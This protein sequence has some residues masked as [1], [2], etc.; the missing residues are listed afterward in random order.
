[1]DQW[2]RWLDGTERALVPYGTGEY[3]KALQNI[4]G[5]PIAL[6]TEGAQLELL[7]AP[8]LAIVGS[9]NPTANGRE[10]AKQFAGYLSRRGL[11]ITSGLATGIDGASHRGAL[12]ELGRTVAV[13]GSGID[14]V[15]PRSHEALA[16]QVAE[17]GLL[18]SE[19]APEAS[20]RG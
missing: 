18:V 10:T 20:A 16:H 13:L 14:V 1:M 9:R 11:T 15:F 4:A 19:Y 6:W 5:P 2:L 7:S 12:R 3:P 8:Q 17:H